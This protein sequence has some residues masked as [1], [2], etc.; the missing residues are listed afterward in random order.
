MSAGAEGCG[1]AAAFTACIRAQKPGSSLAV[2][3]VTSTSSCLCFWPLP[4]PFPWEEGSQMGPDAAIIRY[5]Q[6]CVVT[7][8]LSYLLSSGHQH[9]WGRRSYSKKL[10]E[11]PKGISLPTMPP[12]S[13]GHQPGPV[14]DPCFSCCALPGHPFAGPHGE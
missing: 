13:S 3:G 4:T 5:V 8:V 1:R 9:L 2:V 11:R 14:L 7:L 12:I 10:K 6:R